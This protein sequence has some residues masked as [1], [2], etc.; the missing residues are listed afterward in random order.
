M[1]LSWFLCTSKIYHYSNGCQIRWDI[2][3]HQMLKQTCQ[4]KHWNCYQ[5]WVFIH[6][7]MVFGI[8][9][10]ITRWPSQVYNGDSY[11]TRQCIFSEYKRPWYFLQDSIAQQAQLISPGHNGRHFADDHF[12]CIFVNEIS[13]ILI[14]IPLMFIPKGPINNNPALV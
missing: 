1:Y 14:K 4:H 11:P 3:A 13:C 8:A 2:V 10:P 5:S 9:I 7:D 6:N 12:R